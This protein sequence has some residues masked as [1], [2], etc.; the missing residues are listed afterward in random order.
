MSAVYQLDVR[1]NDPLL[2]VQ[3]THVKHENLHSINA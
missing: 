1:E 3:E 2:V